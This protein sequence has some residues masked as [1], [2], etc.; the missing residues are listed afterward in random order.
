MSSAFFLDKTMPITNYL[1]TFFKENISN[2]LLNF[3]FPAV[4][5]VCN[6][7]LEEN[8]QVV[9]HNCVN[10][11][12][13][14]EE[15]Y[16]RS[17]IK[18]IEKPNFDALYVIFEFDKV[19]QDLI[20]HLKYKRF[21]SLAEFFACE[22]NKKVYVAYDLI[23]GV[24]LNPVRYRERGYNQSGLIAAHLAKLRDTNYSDHILE[25]HIDTPSQTKL[26][27]A[28]RIKNMQGVFRC[29]ENLNGQHV[30]LVDDVI[31]TGST[32]NSCAGVLKT[33]GA[34][35]VDLVSLATPVGF[36]QQ[37]LERDI[38]GSEIFDKST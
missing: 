7:S 35:K 5:I 4:C 15:K 33:A 29:N 32:L 20:H 36:F 13:P 3:L 16:I 28:D 12:K 38:S 27:R 6:D 2:P 11:L 8:E 19:F 24:P 31:T 30:L 37:N 23:L 1:A 25:R 18:E 22:I 34:L 9:C 26:N 14:L 17:L 10:T 21:L